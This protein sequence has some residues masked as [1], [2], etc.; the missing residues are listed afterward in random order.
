MGI[1]TQIGAYFC[2]ASGEPRGGSSAIAPFAKVAAA[3]VTAAATNSRRPCLP[4]TFTFLL[5]KLT[6]EVW[7]EV[8]ALAMTRARRA[9][10]E[11]CLVVAVGRKEAVIAMEA[12][13]RELEKLGLERLLVVRSQSHGGP[14]EEE[15]QYEQSLSV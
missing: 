8:E 9:A 12:I 2:L 6:L 10:V 7:L 14:D 1:V 13:F 15:R 4:S 11:G 5:S 3:T